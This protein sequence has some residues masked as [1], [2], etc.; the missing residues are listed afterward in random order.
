MGGYTQIYKTLLYL[1]AC[2]TSQYVCLWPHYVLFYLITHPH[3]SLY[4]LI[5]IERESDIGRYGKMHTKLH[6]RC[7]KTQKDI[8]RSFMSV[9]TSLYLVLFHYISSYPTSYLVMFCSR[10]S[11]AVWGSPGSLVKRSRTVV[12]E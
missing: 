12:Q 11:R 9:Y 2:P 6:R 8:R 3:A 10:Q 4:P 5:S 1:I 7:W